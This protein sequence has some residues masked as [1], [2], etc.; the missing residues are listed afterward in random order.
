[1]IYHYVVEQNV[2]SV[3]CELKPRTNI[4]THTGTKIQYLA[5]QD[6]NIQV[7]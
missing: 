5:I 2:F 3:R 4:T 1:M 6:F 7:E